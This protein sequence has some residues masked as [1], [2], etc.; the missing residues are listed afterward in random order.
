MNTASQVNIM[1]VKWLESSLTK[2]EV[3]VK[4]AE[5]CLGWPYVFGAVGE[6]CTPSTRKKYYNNYLTRN[7]A[8]S[9]Q[10]K[11]TCR[12]LSNGVSA[13]NGC[14][15]YPGGD[16]RCYDCRGFTRW[17][18][19][20][21]GISLNGAG[22]TSQW[23]NDNNWE[24]KGTIDQYNGGVAV[25]FQK[26]TKKAN[27]MAHTGFLIGNNMIIHC[28]GIVKK[29]AL[30][31]RITH[32]AIPKG[33]GGDIPV[34]TTKPTLKRGSRGPY[35]TLAQTELIAKGFSVGSTGADGIFG[36]KTEDAVKKFQKAVGLNVDGIIGMSTWDALDSGEIKYFKVII[37]H[38]TE[39]QADELKSKYPDA[40]KVQE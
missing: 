18:L 16:V 17:V 21:V 22:A 39:P 14:K 40:E 38:L 35:V 6:Q 11:K 10:I 13:C 26:D 25:F 33:L 29:E 12:V 1:L 20:R 36:A 30:Y 28:S 34:P 24:F 7:P 23:N 37:P 32:F 2:E 19:G 3:V 8:E 5:A 27:T 31:K 4:L 9:E 15:F